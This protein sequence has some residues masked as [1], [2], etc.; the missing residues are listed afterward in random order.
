MGELKGSYRYTAAFQRVGALY[1]ES[2]L[3]LK[4]FAHNRDWEII[5]RKVYQENLL[6]KNSSTWISNILNAVKSRFFVATEPLPNGEQL[7][8]FIACDVPRS[9]KIQVLYQYICH[10]DPLINRLITGLI[11]PLLFKYGTY[12]LTKQMYF[13]FLSKEKESHPELSKWSP[14]VY[15]KWQR[16]FFAFLRFSGI[17]EK[18]PSTKI[19][20]PIVRVESFAFFL[21]GL[22]DRKYSGLE[23]LKNPLWKRYFMKQEDIDYLLSLTQEKGW[24]EYHRIGNIVELSPAYRCLEE[25]L[26]G[27]LGQ[28]E[29]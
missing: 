1:D 9:C 10:S 7:S 13:D 27:A 19:S 2:I 4:Q 3:L 26:N 29:V 11:A 25:W 22:L 8:R 6:R 28:R 21:Y 20:K 14:S 24:I 12:R 23:V 17:M 15:G 16:N 5:K 18:S